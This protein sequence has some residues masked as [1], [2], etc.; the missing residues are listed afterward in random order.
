MLFDTCSL[1]T[2]KM[3]TP[4]ILIGYC[5]ALLAGCRPNDALKT[6]ESEH[7]IDKSHLPSEFY[8][9]TDQT[10]VLKYK[11]SV[12]IP[13]YSSIY[14]LSGER[15]QSLTATLSVRNTS[16]KDTLYVKNVDYYDSQGKLV[17]KY[18]NKPIYVTPLQTIE[19]IVDHEQDKGGT[20]ANFIVNWGARATK[21]KPII[22]AVM[23]GHHGVTFLTDGVATK[24]YDDV[25]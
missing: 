11:E 17:K 10:P 16:E 9:Y 8:H 18:T 1:I 21:M 23:V 3:K 25:L 2:Q 15:K 20:G 13:I 12:Y 22:Q 19:F 14:V 5:I 4:I 6:E 24:I 7:Y